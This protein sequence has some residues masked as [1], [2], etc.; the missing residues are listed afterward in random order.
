MDHVVAIAFFPINRNL[1]F[2]QQAGFLSLKL[3]R[4]GSFDNVD[5]PVSVL[6]FQ[7]QSADLALHAARGCRGGIAFFH[8]SHP[9]ALQINPAR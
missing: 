5:G 9:F 7:R 2:F 8:V 6:F 3:G 1:Y 4:L